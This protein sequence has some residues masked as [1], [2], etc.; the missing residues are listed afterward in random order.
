M[1]SL[2]KRSRP[3]RAAIS[4]L[5]ALALAIVPVVPVAMAAQHDMGATS[6]MAGA[7]DHC[8]SSTHDHATDCPCAHACTACGHAMTPCVVRALVL[9]PDAGDRSAGVPASARRILPPGLPERPP[10]RS[11]S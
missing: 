3:G 10:Q 9:V 2:V 7:P 4:A 5:L 11:R 6:S 8:D 1:S